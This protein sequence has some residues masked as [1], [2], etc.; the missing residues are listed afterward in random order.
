[1]IKKKYYSR[2]VSED[3]FPLANLSISSSKVST[4]AVAIMPPSNKRKTDS[5]DYWYSKKQKKRLQ[6]KSLQQNSN[7]HEPDDEAPALSGKK[8]KYSRSIFSDKEVADQKPHP[9]SYACLE[10]RTLYHMIRRLLSK[11]AKCSQSERL[12]C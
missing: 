9:G 2:E 7:N 12:H 3:I 10:M 4:S 5:K 8:K 11:A 1:M 6:K